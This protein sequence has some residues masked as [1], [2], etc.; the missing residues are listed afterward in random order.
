[1]D[2]TLKGLT[3]DHPRGYAP[4]LKGAPEY[5]NSHPGVRIYWDRRTL[6]EFGEA[7]IEQ[8]LDRYDLIIMDHPFVG[9]AAAHDVLVDLNP[10]LSADENASLARDS[11]GPSA[12]SYRYAD[13]LWALP[14]DAAT[15]V[16]SYRPD[17]LRQLSSKP[18][19][20]LY[21]VLQLGHKA[22]SNG[23]F[24][25]LAACP[26]DAISLFFTMTANLGH[27][28]AEYAEP[29]LEHAVARE[30]LDRLHALIAI[31][32]PKSVKLEPHPGVRPHGRRRTRFIVRGAL[33]IRI[34]LAA[35]LRALQFA[36]AP[37]AGTM[38]CAG[39]LLGGTGVAV[40]KSSPHRDE[41][42][43]YAKW[44]ASL[45]HQRGAYVSEGGQP[46]SLAAWRIRKQRR[47]RR[48]F[49]RHSRHSAISLCAPAL[50][51]I[52]SFFRIRRHRDQS[53]SE[54]RNDRS[55]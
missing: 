3:W 25:V 33:A 11:A 42:V 45:G 5:E 12:E 55:A 51:W 14:V 36:D 49:L 15:Q 6:R 2:F 43:A 46:A 37:A 52:C 39:T 54:R 35:A 13:G 53:L 24:I 34:I 23:K 17:L 19:R 16:A 48:F 10:F 50:Q 31:A 4:L 38:G 1:M 20:T 21:A 47:H 28:I 8:Y 44:L 29:F 30:V 27:P 9:F 18:P 41:A 40:T 7:P 26:I 22:R 32:H